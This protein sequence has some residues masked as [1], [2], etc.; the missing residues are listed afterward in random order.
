MKSGI[1]RALAVI[2]V[3][4]IFASGCAH[5]TV[6]RESVVTTP[7]AGEVV[8]STEPPAPRHEVIGVAPSPRH[9]WVNGYWA[10]THDRWAWVPGHYELGP[11]VGSVWVKGHWDYTGTGWV[12]TPG[13]WA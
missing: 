1:L 7:P 10:R 11:R 2:A 9:V 3:A 13:H 5:R 8:V 12:W 6:V 4:G